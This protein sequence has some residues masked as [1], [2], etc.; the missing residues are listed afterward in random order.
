MRDDIDPK[1][2]FNRKPDM[3]GERIK[4]VNEHTPGPDDLEFREKLRHMTEFLIGE[5][6]T[7]GPPPQRNSIVI[8]NLVREMT[9]SDPDD[10]QRTLWENNISNWRED[11]NFFT[12]AGLIFAIQAKDDALHDRLTM[13]LLSQSSV[14]SARPRR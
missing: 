5:S 14:A 3:P 9:G 10:I 12:A 13:G 2:V 8:A 11:A 6:A 4:S 1:K 7:S